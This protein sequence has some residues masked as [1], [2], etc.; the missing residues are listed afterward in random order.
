MSPKVPNQRKLR[1]RGRRA[2]TP[3]VR[4]RRKKC[5]RSVVTASRRR[6]SANFDRARAASRGCRH[7]NRDCREHA[8]HDPRLTAAHYASSSCTQPAFTASSPT[9]HVLKLPHVHDMCQIPN[10]SVAVC[11][12]PLHTRTALR[13]PR[14]RPWPGRARAR[15]QSRTAQTGAGLRAP[16]PDAS[17]PR[18]VCADQVVPCQKW[19]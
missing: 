9:V 6:P 2:L 15:S 1:V 14:P 4:M 8:K 17:S 18:L 12:A 13:T 11:A 16:H 10:S 5:A 3:R 19:V 7:S